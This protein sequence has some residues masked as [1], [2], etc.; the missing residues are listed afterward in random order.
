MLTRIS[1]FCGVFP[2]RALTTLSLL[3]R[4]LLSQHHHHTLWHLF[5]TRRSA[6]RHQTT[7]YRSMHCVGNLGVEAK[8]GSER[9]KLFVLRV[10]KL[11]FSKLQS[12]WRHLK[13][14]CDSTIELPSLDFAMNL[15]SPTDL[16]RRICQFNHINERRRTLNWLGRWIEMLFRSW[17]NYRVKK[18]CRCEK[19]C[20]KVR[21]TV[22]AQK[23][24]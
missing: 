20:I 1:S 18:V 4:I 10:K 19:I 14:D 21:K 15:S 24:L 3:A 7:T 9:W 12:G 17:T 22:S 8:V 13:T 23:K 11:L 6:W 16:N 5:L 2:K